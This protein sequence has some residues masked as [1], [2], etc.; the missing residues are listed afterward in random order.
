[1]KAENFLNSRAFFSGLILLF[2]LSTSMNLLASW[3]KPA[4]SPPVS[5]HIKVS[6]DPEKAMISGE[7]EI[8]WENRSG[9][10]VPDFWLH[11]YWNAF[12]NEGSVFF[13]E[14]RAETGLA[15]VRP[16]EGQWGWIDLESIRL[17][18]GRDLK[19]TLEFIRQERPDSLDETVARVFFP[20]PI[21]PG[22]KVHLILTFKGKVPAQGMRVG[23]RRQAFFISQWYPKPGVYEAGRGWNC[24]AYH[25][26]SEFYADFARFRV[27]ITTP[28]GFVVAASGKEISRQVDEAARKQTIVFAEDWIHDFAWTAAPDYFK[29]EIDYIP[30]KEISQEE[31]KATAK[32]LG[33]SPEDLTLPRVKMIILLRPEH[34]SQLERHVRALKAAIKYYGLWFGPYPYEQITLVDPPY[35]TGSGGMEYPTLFTAGTSLFLSR[36]VLSPEGVIVHEFGHNYWY[37]LVANNE[38]EEA[39]LDEGLNT[40]STG[41]VLARAFGPGRLSL[42]L[43]QLPLAWFFKLPKY[44]DWELDRATSIHIAST[45][46]IVRLSW[47]FLNRLS[48]GLNV[49]QRASA[50]LYTLE[51][52]LGEGKMLRG[53][54]EFQQRFRFRHPRSEDFFQVMSEVAGQDLDWFYRT[55]FLSAQTFDYGIASLRSRLKPAKL[56]GL[57]DEAGLRKEIGLK[58]IRKVQENLASQEET[59]EKEKEPA[60]Q[61]G[62]E[63][64]EEKRKENR[65]AEKAPPS[66]EKTLKSKIYLNEIIVR[67]YGEARISPD[68]PLKIKIVF[69]DG[70]E[71]IRAWDGQERWARFLLEKESR[72]RL[73]MVDPENIWV[74]DSN[75]ANNSRT[76]ESQ[77]QG[78]WRLAA[79]FF[80]ILQNFLLTLSGLI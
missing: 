22:E 33:L 60:K 54:R 48:Y 46:P 58:D 29:E 1:M 15:S 47:E 65:R 14:A 69:E 44:Y 3:Q 8:I 28:S 61:K 71:E 37:G 24:H 51:R 13:Q 74:I 2:L 34:R 73:A 16:R 43:N 78:I 70:S 31:L 77:N 45:D 9:E 79:S 39:W 5:Y 80:F 32:L 64:K 57:F 17:S 55:F 53:L 76:L 63:M 6:L 7:E 26:N 68:F 56:M 40:Y 19:P 67:R 59:R 10:A 38:F 18:D 20:E 42:A 75:W 4:E 27:E 21:N 66:A 52:L 11:L 62:K 72:V 41:K 36:E 35:G 30:E 49:Y 50:C 25:L 12:K 23:F